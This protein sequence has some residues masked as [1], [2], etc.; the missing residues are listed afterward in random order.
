MGTRFDYSSGG[1]HYTTIAPLYQGENTQ[2]F[3]RFRKSQ[4]HEVK[5]KLK[6]QVTLRQRSWPNLSQ[7]T[8]ISG[9]QAEAPTE[10]RRKE[11]YNHH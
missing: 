3:D 5:T 10:L 7:F 2:N 6:L 1:Y 4:L 8:A 9:V 11:I